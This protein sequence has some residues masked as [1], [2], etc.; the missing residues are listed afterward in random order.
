[1]SETN[2]KKPRSDKGVPRK[3]KAPELTIRE[4]AVRWYATLTPEGRERF[5]DDLQLV[6]WA[7]PECHGSK[8][9][10]VPGV[11]LEPRGESAV[12]R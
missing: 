2:G 10:S 7:I 11:R 12:T 6:D 5:R 9:A 4:Q 3:P 8:T 1:M